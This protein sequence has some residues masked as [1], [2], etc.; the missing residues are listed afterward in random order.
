MAAIDI[1]GGQWFLS[2]RSVL[3]TEYWFWDASRL[4]SLMDRSIILVMNMLKYSLLVSISWKGTGFDSDFVANK[5]FFYEV[6]FLLHVAL[7]ALQHLRYNYRFLWT[8]SPVCKKFKLQI[9]VYTWILW[10]LT[11]RE[12]QKI[13]N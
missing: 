11:K 8:S 5:L 2:I 12:R 7:S 1:D 13:C 3:I 10:Q 4:P 9:I 6:Q